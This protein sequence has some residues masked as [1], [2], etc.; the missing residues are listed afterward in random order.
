MTP[1]AQ[2]FQLFT[3]W[4]IMIRPTL[5]SSPTPQS[6]EQ[7]HLAARSKGR[8]PHLDLSKLETHP[9]FFSWKNV[10]LSCSTYGELGVPNIMRQWGGVI[11]PTHELT[12]YARKDENYPNLVMQNCLYERATKCQLTSYSQIALD[13]NKMDTKSWRIFNRL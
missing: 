10:D 5:N 12:N 13:M 1:Q 3:R 7:H 4:S 6:V 9:S 11:N 2:T 8:V